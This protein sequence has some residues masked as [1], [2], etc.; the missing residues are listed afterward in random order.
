MDRKGSGPW[1]LQTFGTFWTHKI[2]SLMPLSAVIEGFYCQ[3][4]TRLRT[5]RSALA[6]AQAESGDIVLVSYVGSV[7]PAS[8][9][10]Q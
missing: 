4:A 5:R 9:G 10:S 3:L 6:A 2:P 8:A 7:D 1:T